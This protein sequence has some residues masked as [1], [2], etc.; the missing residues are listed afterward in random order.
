[1]SELPTGLGAFASGDLEFAVDDGYTLVPGATEELDDQAFD[2]RFS[3]DRPIASWILARLAR[4]AGGSLALEDETI[5]ICEGAVYV[6]D[7]V[8]RRGKPIGKIQLQAGREGAALLGVVSIDPELVIDRF[9]GALLEAPD[10]VAVCRVR[11][12]D[13]SWPEDELAEYGFDG[14]AYL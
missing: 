1:V 10:D 14:S 6:I 2:R 11:V 9:A 8:V 3:P 5:E 13:P 12:R 7:F 4:I